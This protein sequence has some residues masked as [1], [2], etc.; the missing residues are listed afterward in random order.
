MP[1]AEPSESVVGYLGSRTDPQD[2]LDMRKASMDFH[3]TMG[4]LV[5]HK[6]KWNE[7]DVREGRAQ[8]CPFHSDVYERGEYDP[9]C[10]GT[11]Y[12]GG[13]SDGVLVPVTIGDAQEDVFKPNSQGV[14]IH[15]RHPGLIAPWTPDMGDTDIIIVVEIDPKTEDI[16]QM[17]DR[18][19]L[20]EITPRTIR[21]P[22]FKT[23]RNMKPFK[24]SQDAMI[25]LLPYAHP[26]YNIPINFDYNNIPWPTPPDYPIPAGYKY[27]SF[28]IGVHIV[29]EE[30]QGTKST[31]A[32]DVRMGTYTQ[33]TK[34]ADVRIV[35]DSGGTH[36]HFDGT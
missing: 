3:R 28:E 13:F 2:I 10:F 12:L 21:G 30:L 23:T 14:L 26:F 1:I 29:G 7:Q 32:Q 18:Y 36:F 4:Q 17:G 35:G 19:E 6:H 15:E 9:Y 20:R 22:A 5:I 27:A 24:V 8:H 11:G 34:E 31:R 16:V 25:D 33:S